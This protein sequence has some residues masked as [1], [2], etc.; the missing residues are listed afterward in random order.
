MAGSTV[1]QLMGGGG[2]ALALTVCE[3]RALL[4]VSPHLLGFCVNSLFCIA[5][6]C[7]LASFAIISLGQNELVALLLLCYECHV[8]VIIL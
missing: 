4:F 3:L 1:A 8:A 2:G 6:L 7:V 5:V